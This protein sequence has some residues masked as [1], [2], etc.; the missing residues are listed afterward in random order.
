[1]GAIASA[2]DASLNRLSTDSLTVE[3]LQNKA[4][5]KT[6]GVTVAGGTGSSMA[7]VAIGA[8]LSMLGNAS[9]SSISTTK[10]DI[11]AG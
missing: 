10:S 5:Y 1:G 4:E 8:G 11:A 7:S 3:D 9:D 6:S 2:A